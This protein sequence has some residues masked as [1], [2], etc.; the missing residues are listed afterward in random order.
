MTCNCTGLLALQTPLFKGDAVKVKGVDH[1]KI[2]ASVTSRN[3]VIW[4]VSDFYGRSLLRLTTE[5]TVVC[6][7]S[8]TLAFVLCL[9]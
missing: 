4:H 5:P 7:S 1:R 2:N 9:T 3:R 8:Y 6:A